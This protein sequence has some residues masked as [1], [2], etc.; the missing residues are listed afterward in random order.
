MNSLHDRCGM[1]RWSVPAAHLWSVSSCKYH[2]QA[3]VYAL[4][5]L[6]S[7]LDKLLN[8]VRLFWTRMKI[9]LR[10]TSGYSELPSVKLVHVHQSSG[11]DLPASWQF[12]HARA[13]WRWGGIGALSIDIGQVICMG[14]RFHPPP[15]WHQVC[16]I[17]TTPGHWIN[18]SMNYWWQ[19]NEHLNFGGSILFYVLC[20]TGG[21]LPVCSL[22]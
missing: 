14:V 9:D 19:I 10:S 11:E 18:F 7:G 12:C 15:I 16:T 5:I 22:I 13:V 21:G 4:R 2:W 17:I 20:H 1:I 8:L 3:L 6:L